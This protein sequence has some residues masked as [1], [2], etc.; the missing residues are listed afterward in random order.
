MALYPLK[1]HLQTF[2]SIPVTQKCQIL[3]CEI[4]V[5]NERY[6]YKFE[7]YIMYIRAMEVSEC[8]KN[9]RKIAS[10][11][12]VPVREERKESNSDKA[13]LPPSSQI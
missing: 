1:V 2:F 10:R 9:V 11:Y 12:E 5:A 3:S 13:G 7:L 8:S 6:T 4:L